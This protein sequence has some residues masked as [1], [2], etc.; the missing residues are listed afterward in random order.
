[1]LSSNNL[2]DIS[3]MDKYYRTSD[4]LKLLKFFP[5]A[6]P[7]VD[8]TILKDEEDYLKNKEYLETLK[9]NRV[10]SLKGRML[11][12]GIENTSDKNDFLNTLR[13]VKEKDPLGVLVLFNLLNESS[14]RYKRYAGI[15]I[16]VE[17]GECVFIDAVGKGFDGREVSKSICTHERYYIPWFDLRK[18]CIGNFKNYQT[19]QIANEQ[20]KSSRIERI[21]F[22]KSLGLDSQIVSNYIPEEYEEI[23]D[24]IWLSV[25]KKILKQLEKNE[26]FLLS[27]NLK[28]FVI[29]GHTEGKEFY[30]WQITDKER[31]VLMRK[32]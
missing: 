18:C 1:M 15:G 23:P 31:Y 32:P 7:I 26:D 25:I 30:P 28:H 13:K 20:Y 10:D 11:I 14:E 19:F 5:E 22:L 17:V 6:S 8:F 12:T 29:G 2:N 16:G 3:I 9:T 4:M 27:S 24:F 21:E